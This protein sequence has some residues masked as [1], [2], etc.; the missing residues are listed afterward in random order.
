MLPDEEKS[1][2]LRGS[3]RDFYQV[4]SDHTDVFRFYME[5]GRSLL[6]GLPGAEQPFLVQPGPLG[7]KKVSAQNITD[8]L[9]KFLYECF[10][11]KSNMRDYR[12]NFAMGLMKADYAQE[13]KLW[14][15]QQLRHRLVTQA[16]YYR[17]FINGRR[18]RT[19]DNI[20]PL[21]QNQIPR[22]AAPTEAPVRPDS[23][24]SD[25]DTPEQDRTSSPPRS[26]RV[27]MAKSGF[28]SPKF[29]INKSTPTVP[30]HSVPEPTVPVRK[31]SVPA[32]PKPAN[33]KKNNKK[34][35]PKQ[36]KTL[37]AST[38][39][40]RG[41]K[42]LQESL[43]KAANSPV[44]PTK[45]ELA[46][47]KA[48]QVHL[49]LDCFTISLKPSDIQKDG[50]I[51]EQVLTLRFLQ[52]IPKQWRLKKIPGG[53]E[54]F[55]RDSGKRGM[56]W[57]PLAFG[58]LLRGDNRPWR[59]AAI[60]T[61][62]QFDFMI[63]S[64]N[65][66]QNHYVPWFL[67]NPCQARLPAEKRKFQPF[68][69]VTDSLGTPAAGLA[70]KIL[71]VFAGNDK[72]F[73]SSFVICNMAG[74][75]QALGSN[76]CA[77]YTSMSLLKFLQQPSIFDENP[78]SHLLSRRKEVVQW[79][80]RQEAAK[81]R[82]EAQKEVKRILE[83]RL[84]QAWSCEP[85]RDFEL[86]VTATGQC[87]ATNESLIALLQ[88]F[89]ERN[90][91]LPFPG[92]LITSLTPQCLKDFLTPGIQILE[93][94]TELVFRHPHPTEPGQI[95]SS[96]L[97]YEDGAYAEM[98]LAMQS[99]QATGVDIAGFGLDQQEILADILQSL[100]SNA[101][102]FFIP[103]FRQG[104]FFSFWLNFAQQKAYYA[105][106]LPRG[107]T[108]VVE[109][110]LLLLAPG[111]QQKIGVDVSFFPIQRWTQPAQYNNDCFFAMYDMYKSL[112]CDQLHSAYVTPCYEN[113][114]DKQLR[115]TLLRTIF[116]VE[117]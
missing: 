10:G 113:H 88:G 108:D 114:W 63:G 107:R 84:F 18:L 68:L 69:V 49:T 111:I 39:K 17:Q 76:N 41:D 72:D 96:R 71:A 67:V 98:A 3:P 59:Q 81:E 115:L 54:L 89:P 36:T 25:V 103:V 53:L 58:Q 85:S 16:R 44:L 91:R 48:G 46:Q 57:E 28:I 4:P 40:S 94:M 43:K 6:G 11:E 30:K 20:I 22:P 105:D 104:H 27:S 42:V 37:K 55:N 60:E 112:S 50:F 101:T 65:V 90:V 61:I 29:P 31:Q 56:Y 14:M 95:V 66:N 87:R 116:S 9:R 106:S 52:G 33:T 21:Q 78:G 1:N 12:F 92:K 70:K 117:P 93:A 32:P 15:T 26:H 35:V 19:G 34:R 83:G 45:Q 79:I 77:L 110:L 82:Q 8:V 47:R 5:T 86:A 109:N 23:A 62:D 51:G 2:T 100:T 75:K 102:I 64:A 7:G 80:S 97:P 38:K 99:S 73:A 74:S 24:V 13:H